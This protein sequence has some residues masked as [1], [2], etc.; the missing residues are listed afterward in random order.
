[1]NRATLFAHLALVERHVCDGERH[2]LRQREIVDELE[3][4]GRGESQTTKIAKDILLSIEMAQSAHLNHRARLLL[5]LQ[6]DNIASQSPL[7]AAMVCRR[8]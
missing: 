7:P 4:H 6:G 5:A 3:R 8:I 2:L 1:M